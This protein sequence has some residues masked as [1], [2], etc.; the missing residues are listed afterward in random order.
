MPFLSRV[1]ERRQQLI[2]QYTEKD[3]LLVDALIAAVEAK[4]WDDPNSE[5]SQAIAAEMDQ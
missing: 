5:L 4:D 3:K 2:D 1:A